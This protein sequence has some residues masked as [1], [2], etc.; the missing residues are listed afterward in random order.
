MK[1]INVIGREVLDSRGNPTVEVDVYLEDGSMGRAIVPS[2]ASTGER[3]ALE[4]RDGGTRYNGKGVLQAVENVN[5]PLKELVLG[6]DASNQ[7]E[8]DYVMID[9]DGTKTKSKYG[10]NAILGISMAALKASA[11]SANVPLYK[12]VNEKF[13]NG[14]MSEPYPMMNIINGG[15]HADNKVDFQEFMI[16]PQRDTIKERVRVGAEVFHSL[17]KVLKEKG[18]TTGVGD[19]GGFAPDLQSNEEGFALITEAVSK[20]GYKPGEDVCYAIDVAASEFYDKNSK[21]YKF[22]WSTGEEFTTDELIDF[23]EKLVNTYPIVSIEDPVDLEKLQKDLVI[24]FNLW[25]MIY[26]L[27]IKSAYKKVSIWEQVMLFYLKLIR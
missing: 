4:L 27:L 22:H 14:N 18:Y 16:I 1:I 11:I 6:L 15:A 23:Y 8:L 26:L 17:K 2:G 21:K 25:V 10:A 13:L 9:A 20:A 19:E 12:Y 7:K 3:E 24:G 5:G